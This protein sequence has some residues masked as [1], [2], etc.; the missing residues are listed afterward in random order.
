MKALDT[1]LEDIRAFTGNPDLT[2]EEMVARQE[3]DLDEMARAREKGYYDQFLEESDF[4]LYS[5]AT[6]HLSDQDFNL[7]AGRPYRRVL[8]FGAGIGTRGIASA[9]SG[10]K[11]D[12][13]EVNRTMRDFINFRLSRLGLEGEV[14]GGVPKHKT[15]QLIICMDV[16]GHLSRPEEQL[17][18]LLAQ[19]ESPGEF[20]VSWDNWEDR[21]HTNSTFDFRGLFAKCGLSETGYDTIWLK[22]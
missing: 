19:L 14:W 13:V 12:F 17:T 7:P 22:R 16:I 10:H 1:L 21:A 11:V 9:L 6:W 15:Y 8:D 5:L 20:R 18:E 3:A 2:V 4:Y